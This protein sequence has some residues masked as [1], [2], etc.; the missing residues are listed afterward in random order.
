MAVFPGIERVRPGIEV[1]D[2]KFNFD[3][4]IGYFL[5]FSTLWT[6][7]PVYSKITSLL[8]DIINLVSKTY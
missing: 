2:A 4:E 8:K 5:T 7:F 3:L 6:V 1:I